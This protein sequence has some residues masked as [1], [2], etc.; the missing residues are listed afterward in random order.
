MIHSIDHDQY[1]QFTHYIEVPLTEEEMA[2]VTKA[3][4]DRGLGPINWAR[5]AV[6]HTARLVNDLRDDSALRDGGTA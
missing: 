2:E 4:A 5:N 1:P 6:R 3:A